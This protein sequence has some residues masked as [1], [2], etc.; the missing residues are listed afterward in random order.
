MV[1]IVLVSH[2]R[3][4][5]MG[6]QVFVQTMTGAKLPLAVAAGVGED[7]SEL[8]TDAIEIA[9]AIRSVMS[10][11]GVLVLMDVGSAILS[12]ETA[13]DL[14]DTGM[15]PK[16]RLSSGPFLEGAISAGVTASLGVGLNEVAYEAEHSLHQKLAHF[17]LEP[18]SASAHRVEAA[19]ESEAAPAASCVL[20]VKNL[21][22]LHARPSARLIRESARFQADVTVENV[23]AH[24]GPV[25]ARSLSALAS[26]EVRQGQEMRVTATGPEAQQALQAIRALVEGGLGD[27][28]ATAATGRAAA[29]LPGRAQPVAEG[30]AF[31]PMLFQTDRPADVPKHPAEDIKQET[32]RLHD[33]L[34]TSRANLLQ[35]RQRAERL[36]GADN[37]DIFAMQAMLLDDPAL[38]QRAEELIARQQA[39]AAWAWHEAFCE[40]AAKFRGF[41]DEYLRQRA[42]DIE[43]IGRRVLAELGVQAHSELPL[44]RQGVLV[45]D[46]L[47]PT[48]ASQLQ[49]S[50]VAGVIC[51]DGGATSHSAILL[52]AFGLPCI[53]QARPMFVDLAR[54]RRSAQLAFD[55][56]TGE[57][58][59]DPDNHQ[60]ADLAT[61]RDQWKAHRLQQLRAANQPAITT[62]GHVVE[63]MAN[64]TQLVDAESAV[65]HGAEGIGLLR[66]EFLFLRRAAAPTEDEQVAALAPIAQLSDGRPLVIRTLDAGGDKELPYLGLPPEAN[67]FLGV[68]GLRIC[69]RQPALFETQLRA[70]LRVGINRQ[71][72]IMLP[73][74]TDPAELQ[75]A[76]RHL[77]SSH[78]TL[79]GAHVP[80]LWPVSVGIMVEVPSAALMADDLAQHCD[81]FSIGTNDLTQYTLAADR[82]NAELRDLQDALHPAVL[83]LIQRIVE[84]ARRHGKRVAVCG[85]A[86]ADATAA[87]L[88]VGL[89]VDELSV[90][91]RAVPGIKA[92]M[93]ATSFKVLQD[94]AREAVRQTSA[95]AVREQASRGVN[96][97]LMA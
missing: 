35:Q 75:Q 72:R 55:G 83:L 79:A 36:V 11:D 30:I 15:R 9:E 33:A 46:D 94:L 28:V 23:T 27:H 77:E 88:F 82:G 38:K 91:P 70:L 47:T 63:V 16:I 96:L 78:N 65:R 62:D 54:E 81:F 29:S 37:A 56:G 76:M 67:P 51:L 5:A 64:V 49:G 86:A 95:E 87:L 52:R 2:S 45:V 92:A 73:M 90:T 42:A 8:G 58:W 17:E 61:R 48:Q 31:G 69:L 40:V 21:H 93:R 1:G 10:D 13:L 39:N 24:K 97:G 34:A 6:L 4:L 43:D 53:A 22:G 74:V 80:H 12:A 84:A 89:G 44:N 14:V 26:L 32:T 19:A 60:M 71:L 85:E 68:R 66:T 25:T 59:I 18:E 7:R 3:P 20:A 57:V 50:Q 41:G